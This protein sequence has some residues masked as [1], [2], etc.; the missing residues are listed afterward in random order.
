MS[1]ITNNRISVTAT[2]AQITAVKTALQTLNTNLPFLIGLKIEE[3]SSLLGIDV[4]NK[5]FVEDAISA[6]ANNPDILPKYVVVK[7][8]QSDLALFSQLDELVPLFKQFLEKL[9]D[10]QLLAG[11]EAYMSALML[12]RLYISAAETG[13]AGADTIVA[14][15]KPRFAG[16]GGKGKQ[17]QAP[18]E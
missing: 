7:D 14:Q 10:T 5:A 4:G 17:P 9:M 8:M 1:N 18:T 12:Y 15:L 13:I 16:Q 11:S 2:P 3:R 6:A